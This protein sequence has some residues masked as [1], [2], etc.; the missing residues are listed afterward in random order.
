ME[1]HRLSRSRSCDLAGLARSTAYYKK[2]GSDDQVI[3]DRMKDLAGSHRRYGYL[4][5]HYLLRKEGLVV[6]AKR[7]YRLYREERLQ[8][9]HRKGRTP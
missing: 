9:Y 2:I 5:I 6:N 8:V 7:T 1:A 3:R 4:R